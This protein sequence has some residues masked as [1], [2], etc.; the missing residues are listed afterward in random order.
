[1]ACEIGIKWVLF[2]SDNTKGSYEMMCENDQESDSGLDIVQREGMTYKWSILQDFVNHSRRSQRW[3]PTLSARKGSLNHHQA[4]LRNFPF[5]TINEIRVRMYV[6]NNPM[7]HFEKM[8]RFFILPS[9][10]LS[11]ARLVCFNIITL[12]M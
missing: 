2:C 12:G 3:S 11:I 4:R 5:Y 1:M 10:S 6:L 8:R 9:I 7:P